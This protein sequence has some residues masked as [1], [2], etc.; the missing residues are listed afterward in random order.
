MDWKTA[1]RTRLDLATVV[2]KA[3]SA[4]VEDYRR[5]VDGYLRLIPRE[6]VLSIYQTGSVGMPGLSDIDLI[7]VL[8]GDRREYPHKYSIRRMS[9]QDRY[10]FGHEC[11]LV[12]K[13]SFR[14]LPLWFPTFTMDHLYGEEIPVNRDDTDLDL[15]LMLLVKYLITKLPT[16]LFHYSFYKGQFYERTCEGMVHSVLHALSLW[17]SAG[18]DAIDGSDAFIQSVMELRASWFRRE[19]M[20]RLDRLKNLLVDACVIILRLQHQAAA[21]LRERWFGGAPSWDDWGM[22][23]S[24]PD[25]RFTRTWEK[26]QA[27]Q[28]I[29]SEGKT[30]LLVPIEFSVIPLAFR[31]SDGLVGQHLSGLPGL[32]HKSPDL[33]VSV[34]RLLSTHVEAVEG[35]ARFCARSLGMAAHGYH[36]FGAPHSRKKVRV[37]FDRLSNRF[38]RLI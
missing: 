24:G 32:P 13:P 27:L 26:D 29:L 37:L 35:L 34:T 28:G 38:A 22:P 5:A 33:P 11:D 12:D 10:L 30:M 2:D 6:R 3:Q 21:L 19:G 1:L 4:T 16:E 17:E 31:R 7:L 9:D 8:R 18:G 25:I 36:T 23:A 14:D 15:P 20:D